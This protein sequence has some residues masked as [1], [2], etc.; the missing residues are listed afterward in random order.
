MKIYGVFGI[1][2]HA[3]EVL[4]LVRRQINQANLRDGGS[5]RMCFVVDDA[6]MPSERSTNGVQV[7]STSEF[8]ELEADEKLF[9]VAIGAPQDRRKVTER[10]INKG[11][12]PFSVKASTHVELDCN[13]IGVGA[14]FCHFTQITS[15][16]N[17]GNFFHCNWYSSIGHD[18]VIG[19]YVTFAPGVRCNGN[20]VI[21][22]EAYIGAGAVIRDGT[23]RP[24]TIGK[25]AVIGMGAVVTKSVDPGVTVIGSPARPL[26]GKV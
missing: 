5:H 10:L 25:G 19:D 2:G 20:V 7:V 6:Y 3:R 11:L 17:I 1:G 26:G 12:R 13:V 24:I 15:N 22:D 23:T 14:V 21:E 18:C 9:A 16:I 8:T 4:P